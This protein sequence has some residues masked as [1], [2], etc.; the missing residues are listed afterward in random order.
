MFTTVAFAHNEEVVTKIWSNMITNPN[1]L[2]H[3]SLNEDTNLTLS[4]EWIAPEEVQEREDSY[5]QWIEHQQSLFRDNKSRQDCPDSTIR[6]KPSQLLPY[7]SEVA[8]KGAILFDYEGELLSSSKGALPLD[9]EG[10][11]PSS[12]EGDSSHPSYCCLN[13]VPK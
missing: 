5:C 4:N 10:S 7:T 12:P 13:S 8:H 3:V 11:L 6:E 9:L 2:L 1:S